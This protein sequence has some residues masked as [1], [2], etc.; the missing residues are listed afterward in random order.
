MKSRPILFSGRM[1]EALMAGTKTQTRRVVDRLAGLGPV[2]VFATTDTAGYDWHCRDRRL[3]WH[4][5]TH[6]EALALCPYG[7]VGDTLWCRETWNALYTLEGAE[8]PYY[9]HELPAE[10]RRGTPQ[11]F[12]RVNDP[13]H[14]PTKDDVEAG[15]RW[16]PSVFMPR[17]AC[18]LTLRVTDMR[19][20]HLQDISETDARAEGVDG[21]AEFEALWRTINGPVSWTEN[22]AVWVV[23]VKR[24]TA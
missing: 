4:D 6:S 21:R 19:L 7:Q 13:S 2:S 17:A 9:H 15:F 3:G 5:L 10:R 1:V 24:V 22:P 16:Q 18:R 11:Y 12:Y 23:D 14:V 8:M 20:E